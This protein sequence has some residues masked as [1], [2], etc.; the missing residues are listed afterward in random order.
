MLTEPENI[1]DTVVLKF[2]T[3]SETA[4]M[5]GLSRVLGGY[6]IKS[7]NLEGLTLGR[8]VAKA[9]WEKYRKHTGG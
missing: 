5:A 8:N 3:F 6:H 4:D 9:V 7:D 1:G 2:P